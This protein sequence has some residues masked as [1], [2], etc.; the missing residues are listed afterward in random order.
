MRPSEPL[1]AIVGPTATGK[2][3]LAVA[4][5]QRLDGEL[6][7]ADSRQV[8]RGLAVG[9][10]APTPEEL[11]SVP[12]H[13]VGVRRPD[14]PYTVADWTAAARAVL[15]DVRRR[16]R[17]P[18]IVGG[19]GLYVTALV[20]GWDF[21]GVPPDPV[22]RAEREVL[23]ATPQGLE[24]LAAEVRARDPSAV[25]DLRN[26]RRVVRALEL[27]DAHG[28]PL[29]AARGAAPTE[30]AVIVGLD[31]PDEE[32]RRR[33]E[34][35]ARRLFVEG[36]LLEEVDSALARGVSRDALERA[37]IGYREALAVRDGQL[38][39]EDAVRAYVQRSRRYVRAQ[40]TWFRR[41]PRIRWLESPTASPEELVDE[42]ID[43]LHQDARARQRL[44]RRR[45]P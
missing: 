33:L 25:V 14:E 23:A 26:P 5:A 35:R 10:F 11:G 30:A 29:A 41:D 36:R 37:G 38:S 4:V 18:I 42:V 7:N 8:I 27:L 40:R 20:G 44:P 39:V 21:G 16:G 6:V 19:T 43:A 9:T 2:T 28:G 13:L 34:D 17:R 15:A 1:L 32:H 45:R 31:L 22:R 3:R 12:C 24:A